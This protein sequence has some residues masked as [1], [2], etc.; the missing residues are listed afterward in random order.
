M[1]SPPIV[2]QTTVGLSEIER[3]DKLQQRVNGLNDSY[4]SVLKEQ[5]SAAQ[6]AGDEQ[7]W[8]FPPLKV[9]RTSAAR[10]I[11]ADGFHRYEV[12]KDKAHPV[13]PV[14][15]RSGEERDAI[16]FACGANSAHGLPATHEDRLKAVKTLC[17][18]TYWFRLSNR[19]IASHCGVSPTTV[20]KYRQQINIERVRQGLNPLAEDKRLGADGKQRRV[21]TEKTKQPDISKPDSDKI[22][23]R[24]RSRARHLRG[25]S[26]LSS[27]TRTLGRT[28]I[29][30]GK[31]SRT[32]NPGGTAHGFLM[33][34]TRLAH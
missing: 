10:L 9:F 6:V 22:F 33:T 23:T 26:G 11:L 24:A 2:E 5:Y 29:R 30:T 34:N 3:L 1:I 21:K 4:L 19:Q 7:V 16:L 20:G 27:S 8:P 18:D 14:A 13:V 31:S 25:I 32:V 17:S 15:V 28:M 12:A